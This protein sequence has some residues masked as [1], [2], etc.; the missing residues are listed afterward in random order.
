MDTSAHPW[1]SWNV[2]LKDGLDYNARSAAIQS[3]EDNITAKFQA[4]FNPS[5]FTLH[6][7]V[8]YCP[9]DSSLYNIGAKVI[10]ASGQSVTNPPPPPPPP[11]GSGDVLLVSN[12]NLMVDSLLDIADS[13]KNL[14]LGDPVKP[15]KVDPSILAIIDTGLDTTYFS[16]EIQTLVWSDPSG[17]TIYDV[18]DANTNMLFDDHPGRHGTIVTGLALQALKDRNSILGST[19]NI[20]PKVMV[21]KALNSNKQGST[22]SVS[23][24]LSYAIQHK[25]ALVNASLGYLETTTGQIDAVFRHYID[26][27]H[28]KT[29]T[30]FA[31][32][33]NTPGTHNP[34]Q[35][36]LPAPTSNQLG[37][38]RMFYPACFTTTFSN[39]LAVTGLADTHHSCFYQNYSPAIVELG[40]RQKDLANCCHFSVPFANGE[41]TSFATPVACGT[42]LSYILNAG[43]LNDF[44]NSLSREHV[45]A[46]DQGW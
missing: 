17:S 2:L 43:S 12:N 8:Y 32:A 24:A 10:D 40:V 6:L 23:C 16:S 11:G 28:T 31:A 30:V 38:S 42:A 35:I 41:G 34:G 18:V 45:T 15:T 36:C 46:G 39:V 33:G 19:L 44:M 37:P 13:T 29:I 3:V 22:F 7:N 25:A 1:G 14:V 27:C 4:T 5:I 9:C 21:L 26:L 20:L